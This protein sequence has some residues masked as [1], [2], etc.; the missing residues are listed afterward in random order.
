MTA[1]RRSLFRRFESIYILA[2]VVLSIGLW[3]FL[4][5]G[6]KAKTAVVEKNGKIIDTVA[7]TAYAERDY[8]GVIIIFDTDGVRIK[9]SPCKDKICVNTGIINKSG[10]AAVCL[11]MEI[12]VRLTGGDGYDSVTY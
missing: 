10:E 4:S 11:P 3:L 8:G 7:L 1:S 2:L 5:F 6:G 12:S 9:E